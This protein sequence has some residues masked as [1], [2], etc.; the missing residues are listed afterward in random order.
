M[1][2]GNDKVNCIFATVTEDSNVADIYIKVII[3]KNEQDI[4]TSSI[5]DSVVD[6][7]NRM[8][9][10]M[11]QPR[12]RSPEFDVLHFDGIYEDIPWICAV[13]GAQEWRQRL[14]KDTKSHLKSM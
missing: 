5:K 7:K 14:T 10:Y 3:A 8:I 9:R 6:Q 1:R 11:L 13:R 12:K 4:S 2:C